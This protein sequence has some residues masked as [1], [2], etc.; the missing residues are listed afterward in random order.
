M[1]I[2]KRIH[3]I[4]AIVGPA[5]ENLHFYRDVLGLRLIKQTVNFEDP[6]VYHLYFANDNADSGTVMTFFPWENGRIGRKGSGQVGRIAFRIP[7]GRLTEWQD[8]LESKGFETTVTQ[9][10]GKDTLE[11]QDMHYLDIALVEGDEEAETRAI[12]G[13]HGT[14]LL[15]ANPDDTAVFLGGH[16]GLKPYLELADHYSYVTTGEEQHHILVPK[17]AAERGRWGLG[18]VHHIAWSV[19]DQETHQVWRNHWIDN[20][21]GVTEVKDRKY[22]EAIYMQEPGNVIFEFA[23]D[24]PGFAVDEPFELLGQSLQLPPQFEDM[25]SQIVEHLAPL[26]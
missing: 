4:S 14:V 22:F 12:L 9:L 26:D 13:F 24:G 19:P 18:T 3:H 5:Q 7:K 11:F 20:Q 23:T 17:V 6:Y 25:R 10:F 16:L 2:I 21:F 8:Y 15:S 1:P